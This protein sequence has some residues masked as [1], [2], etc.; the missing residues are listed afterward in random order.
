MATLALASCGADQA[1][2]RIHQLGLVMGPSSS[3]TIQ[4]L[5]EAFR[6]GL[7]DHGYVDGE[8]IQVVARYCTCNGRAGEW[9]EIAAEVAGMPLDVIVVP[10]TAAAQEATLRATKTIPVVGTMERDPVASGLAASLARPA[11]NLTGIFNS[12]EATSAKRLELLLELAPRIKRV[13]AISDG[14]TPSGRYSVKGAQD[15]ARALNV[16]VDDLVISPG[17]LQAGDD[18]AAR[19]RSALPRILERAT[20]RGIDAL[21]VGGVPF[22]IVEIRDEI[23]AYALERRIPLAAGTTGGALWAEAGA[24][25]T[26]GADQLEAFRRLAYFV[27]RIL[28][29]TKAGDIPIEQA[30]KFETILNLKTAKAIGLTI[31]PSV[32]SRATRVIE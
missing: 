2:T 6:A 21:L 10:A 20:A 29:G 23:A 1:K 16:E 12:P 27:D 15:A 28:K 30:A 9:D 11:G 18:L 31:P 24:L 8:T 32:M 26:F 3:E 17:Q 14:A 13:G 22:Y 7:R 4:Q 25:V 19:M 5:E